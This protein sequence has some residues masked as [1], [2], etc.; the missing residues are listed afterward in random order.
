MRD[1][2]Q[3]NDLTDKFGDNLA[4]IGIPTNQFGHQTNESD[5]EVLNT[6]K[7]V[8]PG[9]GYEPKFTLTTKVAANGTSRHPV[10]EFLCEAIT[11]PCDDKAG[12]GS[13]HIINGT[14]PQPI[15][16]EPVRRNDLGWNFEKFLVN[17][18]GVPVRRYSPKFETKD[19][20]ADIEALIKD[21][22]AFS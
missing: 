2:I 11:E 9:D 1:F 15:L 17:Q 8:R 6:L 3:M 20:A 12:T 14:L 10:F 18:D 16:W 22:K 7:Y 21:P 13:S 5:Q 4:V 19:L